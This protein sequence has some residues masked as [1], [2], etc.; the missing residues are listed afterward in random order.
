MSVP[1]NEFDLMHEIVMELDKRADEVYARA[2]GATNAEMNAL[3]DK[4]VEETFAKF[5]DR[6]P[7]GIKKDQEVFDQLNRILA[8][9]DAE[10]EVRMLVAWHEEF[11]VATR[12][13]YNECVAKGMKPSI[14][15]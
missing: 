8:N 5:K 10:T 11:F 15:A 7:E 2:K 1:Q 9:G 12:G 13:L 14:V 3:L 6:L 4:V